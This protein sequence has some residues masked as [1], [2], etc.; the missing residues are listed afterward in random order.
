MAISATRGGGAKL[1]TDD[2][3]ESDA[4]E[5]AREADMVR[6]MDGCAMIGQDLSL[7]LGV[8]VAV[9]EGAPPYLPSKLGDADPFL[10]AAAEDWLYLWYEEEEIELGGEFRHTFELGTMGRCDDE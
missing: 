3:D 10:D 5:G 7:E 2:D 4:R 1:N 9:A 8:V 6:G